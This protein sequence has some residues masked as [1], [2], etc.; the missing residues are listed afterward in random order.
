MEK[1]ESCFRMQEKNQDDRKVMDVIDHKGEARD[2]GAARHG[3]F[4]QY[5][6]Y[7]QLLEVNT[8]TITS[9]WILEQEAYLIINFY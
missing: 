3:N 9:Y 6:Q 1:A 2:P 5:C 4:I 7:D 8:K